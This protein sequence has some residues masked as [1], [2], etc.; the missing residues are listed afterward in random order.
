MLLLIM[1]PLRAAR[2]AR[3]SLYI[4]EIATPSNTGLAMTNSRVLKKSS[5]RLYLFFALGR[6]FFKQLT[7]GFAQFRRDLNIHLHKFIPAPV[8]RPENRNALSSDL[9]D[10][11]GQCTARDLKPGH[12]RKRR[13]LHLAAEHGYGVRD[14]NLAIDVMAFA[15]ESLVFFH[16]H[17]DIKIAAR[18]TALP[19]LAFAGHAEP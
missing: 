3:Q 2:T 6:K 12:S 15:L 18:C 13:Y 11:P 8:L 7:L 9:K 19:G 17:L 14:Q 4:D 5:F 16:E 10:L 1:T